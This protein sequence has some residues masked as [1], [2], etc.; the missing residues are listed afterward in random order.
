MLHLFEF[1]VQLLGELMLARSDR[2]RDKPSW[3][4]ALLVLLRLAIVIAA[5]LLLLLVVATGIGLVQGL[6]K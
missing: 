4:R 2:W 5:A 6:S 1:L 3:Q